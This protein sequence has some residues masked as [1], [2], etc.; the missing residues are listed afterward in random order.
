MGD[1]RAINTWIIDVDGTLTDGGIYYDEN[2][3]EMKKFCT[4][5]A[6]AFFVCNVLGMKTIV[7]TGRECRATD[8]RLQELRVSIIKQGVDDKYK[9]LKEYMERNSISEREVGFIGDD[10]NDYSAMQLCGF[11]GCPKTACR[12][13]KTI[14]NYVSPFGGGAGAVRDIVEYVLLQRGD[15]EKA[16][17]KVYKINANRFG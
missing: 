5:D 6:A 12:E 16:I 2:G 15:W 8:R 13:I 14:A 4:I 10:L 17:C 3:N 1:F 11:V 7:L 9:W